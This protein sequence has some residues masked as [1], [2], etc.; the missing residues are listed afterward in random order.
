MERIYKLVADDINGIF[1]VDSFEDYDDICI[2]DGETF[3]DAISTC[4]DGGVYGA[5]ILDQEQYNRILDLGYTI[6]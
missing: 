3:I 4:T 2:V 6:C 1:K 5:A